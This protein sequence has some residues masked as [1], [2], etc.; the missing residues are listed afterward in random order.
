MEDFSPVPIEDS[1]SNEKADDRPRRLPSFLET[2]L[3]SREEKQKHDSKDKESESKSFKDRVTSIFKDMF[4]RQVRVEPL[5]SE[6]SPSLLNIFKTPSERLAPASELPDEAQRPALSQEMPE[7]AASVSGTIPVEAIPPV[8][9]ASAERSISDEEESVPE[10]NQSQTAEGKLAHPGATES[11][12]VQPVEVPAPLDHIPPPS[13]RLRSAAVS[14]LPMPPEYIAA[15]T[16]ISERVVENYYIDRRAGVGPALV[17]FGASE[18]LSRRRNRKQKHETQ[19]LKERTKKLEEANKKVIEQ[20]AQSAEKVSEIV[21]RQTAEA[22]KRASVTPEKFYAKPSKVERLRP[23]RSL[24]RVPIPKS[25]ESFPITPESLLSQPESPPRVLKELG[26]HPAYEEIEP[27]RVLEKVETVVEH[28]IPIEKHYERRHEIKDEPAFAA[29]DASN[30]MV[31]GVPVNSIPPTPPPINSPLFPAPLT[32]L[33]SQPSPKTPK[34]ASKNLY[35]QAAL[36]GA[37]AAV[38]A[39]LLIVML[40]LSHR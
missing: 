21:R 4:S 24:D 7:T 30:L 38:I 3:R 16:P 6:K 9:I 12:P 31:P 17:A 25:K 20:Q 34:Q 29:A 13:Q 11:E 15:Q 10:E 2:Y 23:S 18:I 27:K 14:P 22:I 5:N 36:G 1:K 35:R 37:A 39:A 28:N 40:L 32:S 26:F 8:A 33:P 19:K